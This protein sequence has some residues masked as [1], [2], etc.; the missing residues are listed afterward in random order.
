MKKQLNVG[1][2]VTVSGRWPRELP[3]KRFKEYG[4]WAESH[5]PHSRVHRFERLVCTK[6]DMQACIDDFRRCGVDLIV[7]VYGAF[8]G[9]DIACGLA[10]ALRVPL[11]LWAP[12]EEQWV[13]QDRLYA[14]A[15]CSATMN[16]ASLRRIGAPWHIVYGNREEARVEKELHDL[17][18]AYAARKN[19]QGLTFGLFGY[20]P[21]A[22]Y[23]CAFDEG[24]IR[25]PLALM[26]RRPT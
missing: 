21:T 26:W 6:E 24:A 17:V 14:N 7:L 18:N 12:R 22:F 4:D 5:L 20:R 10:D 11:V 9:D 13:R 16:G 8:T 25:K 15:L 23:N 2:I 3:E 1:F 19:L